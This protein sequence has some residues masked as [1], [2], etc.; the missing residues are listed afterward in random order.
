MVGSLAS[1]GPACSGSEPTSKESDCK[2]HRLIDPARRLGH[3]AS[4]TEDAGEF[5][6]TEARVNGAAAAAMRPGSKLGAKLA[7]ISA[8]KRDPPT[9]RLA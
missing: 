1:S 9:H 2:Y 5:P 8:P 4:D 3:I 6:Y 7:C